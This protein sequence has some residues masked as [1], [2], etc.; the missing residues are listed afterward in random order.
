MRNNFE[1]D[2]SNFK[3]NKFTKGL[4]TVGVSAVV[5][6]SGFAMSTTKINPGHAGI[7][8]NVS[9]GLEE[10]TL[11]QGWHIVALGKALENIQF[12]LKPYG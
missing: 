10:I 2:M 3:M 7:V 11:S 1:I 8:Y 12:Q 4:I 9:G 5:L 6:L